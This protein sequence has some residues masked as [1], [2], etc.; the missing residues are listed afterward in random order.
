MAFPGRLGMRQHLE[1]EHQYGSQQ[2]KLSPC[3]QVDLLCEAVCLESFGN[4][5]ILLEA[6][7]EPIADRIDSP[8]MALTKESIRTLAIDN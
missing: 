6:H 4:T 3:T 1:K 2:H 8:K 5:W 7:F